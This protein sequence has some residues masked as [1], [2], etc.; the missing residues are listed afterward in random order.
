MVRCGDTKGDWWK[1]FGNWY[2]ARLKHFKVKLLNKK[3]D[4]FQY[5]R[6]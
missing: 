1:I 2:L 4:E 5:H 3:M 6:F